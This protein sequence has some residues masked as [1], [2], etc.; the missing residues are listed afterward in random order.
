[1]SIKNLTANNAQASDLV[2]TTNEKAFTVTGTLTL[3]DGTFK[4]KNAGELHMADGATISIDRNVAVLNDVPTLD[5]MVNVTYTNTANAS[6]AKELPTSS[7]KLKNL[8]VNNN[9]AAIKATLAA[10]ATVNGTI[11]LKAGILDNATKQVTLVS[12]GTIDR[13]AGT[14]STKPAATAYNLVYSASVNPEGI[15]FVAGEVAKVTVAKNMTWT[16]GANQTIGGLDLSASNATV[17]VTTFKLSVQGDLNMAGGTVTFTT[18]SLSLAGTTKQTFTVPAAG[19]TLNVPLTLNNAAGFALTGGNL[20]MGAD[21]VFVSGVLETGNYMVTLKQT[22]T[23][24]GFDN[25]AVVAPVVSHINGNVKHVIFAGAGNP[26]L[27]NPNGRFEFPVGTATQYRPFIVTFSQDYPAINPTNLIVKMVDASPTGTKNLPLDGGNGVKIGN[28]PN[29]YWLVK[30]TPSSF[31]NTQNFDIEMH[32][33]NIGIPYTS[34]QDLRIIRRQDGTSTSNGWAMQGN[35]ANYANYQ[36]VTGADTLAVVRTTSSIGGIVNEGTRFAIGVPARIPVFAADQ[37]VTAT[38]AE[39]ATTGNTL[40]VTAAANNANESLTYS[41]INNAPSFVAINPTTGLM[42]FTPTYGNKGTYP[43]SIQVTTNTGLS[44]TLA[45]TLTVTKTDRAPVFAASTTTVNPATATA[46]NGVQLSL[47]YS[48][49]DADADVIAYSVVADKA[50]SVAPVV[51]AA[52][53]LTWT[54]AFADVALSPVT[55]TVTASSGTPVAAATVNTVVTVS[56]SALKGDADLNG[57]VTSADASEILKYVVGLVTLTPEALAAADANS[58]GSVGALDA[59]WVLY[60]AVNGAFPVAKMVA[61][62]GSV[63]FG[64]FASNNG[65]FS[66]PINLQNSRGVLSVYSEVAIG[67]DV[68][69]KGISVNL[70][71]GWQVSSNFENGVL[72]VAMAGLT[73]LTDGS[74][75][76]V[77]IA[78][79]NAESSVSVN[80]SV[81]MNDEVSSAMQAVKVREIPS[82]FSLSQNYPNPF[83]PTTTIKYAISA[84]ARVSLVVYNILGQ[85]VKTLVDVDQEAGFYTAK[86]DGTN[87]FGSKVSSGI[88]IYRITAGKFVS[89]IK[90]NLLK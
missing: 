90:M 83:N 2:Q 24:P 17:A 43:F 71:E 28:Y 16:L 44:N 26:T 45:F 77:N 51:S 75:A 62:S 79:K 54:P 37:A 46:K 36:S 5:G 80:G 23:S 30:T 84:D 68:N 81:K 48:A 13:S 39:A 67:S 56:A 34:D 74:I 14:I 31:T 19:Y 87:D 53:A 47:T 42:T 70:P 11:F 55:F 41:L 60:K 82:D 21:I 8:T 1:L 85:A 78:L 59:A 15:E 88:Y 89:T 58:D 32:G 10:V 49:T 40:Q 64:K 6:T 50:V 69:Y 66:L 20:T 35:Y 65:T 4:T 27:A 76:I 33:T 38:V 9:G 7:T 18:G 63:E 25:T 73:P 22:A 29:Y 86:W 57:S 61:A 52:G 12:G 72:K 3:T